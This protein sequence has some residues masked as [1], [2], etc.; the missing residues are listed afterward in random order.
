[1]RSSGDRHGSARPGRESSPKPARS[2]PCRAADP[3]ALRA[4]I[5]HLV[6]D[7]VEAARLGAAGRKVA[8][9]RFATVRS[10]EALAAIIDA[11]A[12]GASRSPIAAKG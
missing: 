1:M 4:A 6:A 8:L 9:E 2:S 3:A 12:P 11:V 5:D 10:I 7:P